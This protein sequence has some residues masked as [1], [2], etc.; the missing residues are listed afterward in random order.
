MISGIVSTGI[1]IILPEL[2]MN[3]MDIAD[4]PLPGAVIEDQSCS[5]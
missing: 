2:E 4:D 3:S 5:K 1:F